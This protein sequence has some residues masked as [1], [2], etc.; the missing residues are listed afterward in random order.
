VEE[1]RAMKK[2]VEICEK[3]K[4]PL[5]TDRGG[6]SYCLECAR[7]LRRGMQRELALEAE[8]KLR[9]VS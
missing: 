8:A 2:D 1:I 3:H 6:E 4:V 7:E 9:K 5:T